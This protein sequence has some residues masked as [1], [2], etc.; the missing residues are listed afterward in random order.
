MRRQLT[1]MADAWEDYVYWQGQDKKTLKRINALTQDAQR[2]PFDGLGK[3]EPLKGNLSGYWSRRIDDSN[4]LVYFANDDEL[5][6]I[7]CRLHYGDK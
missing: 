5:T 4:R 1:F 3:P 7:A 6:I 2:E